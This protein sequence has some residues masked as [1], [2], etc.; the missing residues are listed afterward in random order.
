MRRSRRLPARCGVR[1]R[2]TPRLSRLP[3]D[4]LRA[5]A[6]RVGSG[7]VRTC[8]SAT[9]CVGHLH[10]HLLVVL[11]VA[12]EAETDPTTRHELVPV[13]VL[14][15][16]SAR[17]VEL[18]V[19]QDHGAGAHPRAHVVEHRSRRG[20]KIGRARRHLLPGTTPWRL[21]SPRQFRASTE[22]G[23]GH[24]A[25]GHSGTSRVPARPGPMPSGDVERPPARR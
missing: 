14:V 15:L 5:A 1:L 11:G 9:V 2:A 12:R 18:L 23:T 17:V 4:P 7:R 13:A 22:P 20:V 19:E 6:R 16:L 24:P 8:P 21:P 25:A 3:S 10:D